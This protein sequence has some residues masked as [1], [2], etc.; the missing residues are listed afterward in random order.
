MGER[1][2]YWRAWSVEA[3]L[4]CAWFVRTAPARAR[5]RSG[6]RLAYWRARSG[7]ALLDCAWL[8][9]TAP[10][11]ARQRLAYWRT[12]SAAA[13]GPVSERA[14]SGTAARRPSAKRTGRA[15]RAPGRIPRFLA[16]AG[17]LVLV[18]A[19]A[20]GLVVNYQ[21]RD[22]APLAAKAPSNSSQAVELRG[23]VQPQTAAGSSRVA[24]QARARQARKLEAAAAR[25]ARAR[26]AARRR[27]AAAAPAPAPA[28]A[29]RQRATPKSENA[30]APV[31]PPAPA[32]PAPAPQP[33]AQPAP[34]P[35]PAPAPQPQSAPQGGV[36]F[37]DEG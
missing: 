28:P 6:E 37:D 12:R 2:A 23:V 1:F 5:E 4:D 3:L 9:R 20:A 31:P 35:A 21:G 36:P 30:S 7:E 10:T 33:V 34:A 14:W 29:A 11:R 16:P 26:A 24:S 13:L 25:R 15:P 18:L 32:T 19:A 8:V 22:E 17:A 27:S